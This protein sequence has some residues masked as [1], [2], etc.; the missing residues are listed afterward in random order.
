LIDPAIVATDRDWAEVNRLGFAFACTLETHIHAD[1]MTGGLTLKKKAGS[2]VAASAHDR[3]RCTD[4]GIEDGKPF[5]MASRLSHNTRRATLT[6]VL[7][8]AS[9]E[10]RVLER[11]EA[12]EQA[13]RQLALL[14]GTDP[15]TGLASRRRFSDVLQAEWLRALRT[16]TSIGAAM[17]DID[18][19]KLYN[20]HNGHPGDDDCLKRV[21]SALGS[22]LRQGVDLVARYG[23]EEFALILPGADYAA[24][25]Q[26]AER[27]RAA[28]AALQKPHALA[29]H[30]IVTVS[31]GATA[32][33]PTAD[34]TAEQMFGMADAALYDTKQNG[35]NQVSG[36]QKNG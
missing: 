22:G 13:N 35:R 21:A 34:N 14:S 11:T 16:H 31:V 19:F 7:R 25:C 15:L 3:L 9:L 30:G 10:Q 24:T 17:I 33:T 5:W 12:L 29:Q 8:Y 1:H 27:A 32:L 20:D 2:R 4:F 28:A 36:R 23:G 6:G 26:A 18:Q